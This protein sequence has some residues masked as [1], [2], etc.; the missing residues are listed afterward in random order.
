[1]ASST[2]AVASAECANM[3]DRSST[4][5]QLTLISTA[6]MHEPAYD[7]RGDG[8]EGR[9]PRVVR[10]RTTPDAH[11]DARTDGLQRGE[12][13]GDPGRQPRS[14][15]AH[16]VQH[17]GPDFVHPRPGVARPRVDGERLDDDRT[18]IAQPAVVG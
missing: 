4:L 6:S 3:R 2:R 17:A 7:G 10:H 18:E 14:L 16:A 15:Q 11:D 12:I 9:R 1:M 5:G 8:D 13:I